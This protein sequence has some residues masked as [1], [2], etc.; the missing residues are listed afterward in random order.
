MPENVILEKHAKALRALWGGVQKLNNATVWNGLARLSSG[1]SGKGWSVV[2]RAASAMNS[3]PGR[4]L[5][6]Y[7][8]AGMAMPSLPGAGLLS[9]VAMPGWAAAGLAENGIRSWRMRDPAMQARMAEDARGGASAAGASFM[10][11][12]AQTP[13][14]LNGSDQYLRNLRARGEDTTNIEKFRRGEF[15]TPRSDFS[16][17]YDAQGLFD[18]RARNVAQ[19]ALGKSAK[20]L[21]AGS[22][23]MNVGT[24]LAGMVGLGTAGYGIYDAITGSP[25]D[26]ASAAQTGYD[27]AQAGI[28]KKIDSLPFWQRSLARMDPTL[29]ASSVEEKIPGSISAW[30]NGTGRKFSP[31][32]LGGL[33]S[34][35]KPTFTTF[36]GQ[37][38]S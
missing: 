14:I 24:S 19:Q 35:S 34:S 18:S 22:K 4:A 25:Y 1:K 16:G 10:Q 31:G 20:L 7:G 13:D 12:A 30:E 11:D 27:A 33:T 3:I 36:E 28:T 29:V 8:L 9:S 2:N 17:L 37:N 32:L 6:Y 15:N 21:A 23:L 5:G 26:R 38:I